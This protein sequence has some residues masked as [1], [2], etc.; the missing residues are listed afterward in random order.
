MWLFSCQKKF[1][2]TT[3]QKVSLINVLGRSMTGD[4]TGEVPR[5]NITV[6]VQKNSQKNY[7]VRGV[8]TSGNAMRTQLDVGDDYTNAPDV[9]GINILG[10]RL[11][12]LKNRK[13][14]CSKIVRA[15]YE[16]GETFLADKYSDY[17]IELPKMKP[18][19]K[20]TLPEEYHELWDLCCIFKAKVKEQKEVIRMEAIT[21]S[22]ALNLAD[23]VRKV[24]A[25]DEVVWESLWSK[26]ELDEFKEYVAKREKKVAENAA[27]TAERKGQEKMLIKAIKN[28]VSIET[29]ET[30]RQIAGITEARFAQ[31]LKQAQ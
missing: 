26:E 9:I 3:T 17:F 6:E 20:E 30:M 19:A 31:L 25:P 5:L 28:N 24:V 7:A 8:L 29:L 21:S 14:F 10:F 18:F 1:L 12:E 4:L 13:I 2:L 23:E 15:E 22:A 27:R 11:P 16:T